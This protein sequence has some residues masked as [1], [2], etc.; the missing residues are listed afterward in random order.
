LPASELRIVLTT[1]ADHFNHHRP[2][3]PYNSGDPIPQHRVTSE[4]LDQSK[5]AGHST[6]S[7]FKALQ[8]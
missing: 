5:H 8:A 6:N 1:Y 3:D 4:K 2:T 7:I